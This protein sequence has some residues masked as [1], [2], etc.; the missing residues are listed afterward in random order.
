MA[1]ADPLAAA[2][3]EIR[4]RDRRVWEGRGNVGGLLAIGEAKDDVPRLLAAVEAVLGHHKPRQ[5]YGMVESFKGD[6]LCAHGPDYDGDAHFLADDGIWY[7]RDKPTVKV[8]ASCADGP[9]GDMW[10][11]WPCT[12]F[13]DITRALLGEE[14]ASG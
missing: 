1:D 9:D 6:P 13:K 5:L 7:C 12:T 8:C 2:M 11:E 10:A 14:K 4:D 3:E